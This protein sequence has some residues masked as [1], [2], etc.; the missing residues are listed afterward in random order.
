M[1]AWKIVNPELKVIWRFWKFIFGQKRKTDFI[2]KYD[3]ILYSLE[4]LIFYKIGP[5]K[6]RAYTTRSLM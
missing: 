3:I 4:I 6:S 1:C 5:T 2:F